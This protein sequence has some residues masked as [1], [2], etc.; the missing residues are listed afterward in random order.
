MPH[1][2]FRE[3]GFRRQDSGDRGQEAGGRRQEA[4]SKMITENR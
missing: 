3:T 1:A 2:G 4:E